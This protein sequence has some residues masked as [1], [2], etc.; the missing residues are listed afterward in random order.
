MIKSANDNN[1]R[2]K[3]KS[4]PLKLTFGQI[5]PLVTVEMTAIIDDKANK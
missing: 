1:F 4:A 3:I 2:A 5:W